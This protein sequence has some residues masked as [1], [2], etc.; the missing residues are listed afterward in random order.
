VLRELRRL[1][2]E[3]GGRGSRAEA[4]LSAALQTV[5]NL[6]IPHLDPVDEDEDQVVH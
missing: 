6:D 4:A 2:R 5:R 3:L 1:Q